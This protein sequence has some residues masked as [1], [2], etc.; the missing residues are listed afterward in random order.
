[1]WDFYANL[2]K[3]VYILEPVRPLQRRSSTDAWISSSGFSSCKGVKFDQN[4]CDKDMLICFL[5]LGRISF[6]PSRLIDEILKNGCS[7]FY[8]A[9]I[10]YR[11]DKGHYLVSD[12][13]L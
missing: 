2:T 12:C 7:L 3:H 6:A 1:M 10:E 8:I 11:G 13:P 9:Y 4:D 5:V